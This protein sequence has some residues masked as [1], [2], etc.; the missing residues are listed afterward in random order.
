M[1]D[2]ERRFV[3]GVDLDGVCADFIGG[4]RPIAADWLGVKVE[5]LTESPSYGFGEWHLPVVGGAEGDE[6]Y[7]H[8]HRYAVTQRDLF[9]KLPIIAG[10]AV[11]LR[12]LSHV[13]RVRI[14]IITHRLFI[15]HF[16]ET[17]IQQTVH[18]LDEH[19]IPYYDLCFMGDKGAVDADRISKTRPK[20]SWLC[21]T[22]ASV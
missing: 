22:T 1:A 3:L 4:L 5:D 13:H 18:W 15:Q 17:A 7:K 19:D 16:H 21:A 20:I 11:S 10:A 12:K 8:L 14:R 6:A 9:L 2:S